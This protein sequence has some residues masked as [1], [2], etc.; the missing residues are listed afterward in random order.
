MTPQCPLR[1]QI[2]AAEEAPLRARLASYTRLERAHPLLRTDAREVARRLRIIDD[3]RQLFV[4]VRSDRR[5]VS[6]SP[7]APL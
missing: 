5:R 4:D 3:A 6:M 7:S 1:D 2:L